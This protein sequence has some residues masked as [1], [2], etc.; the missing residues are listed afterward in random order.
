MGTCL[1][2]VLCR[3]ADG[4]R[5]RREQSTASAVQYLTLVSGGQDAAFTPQ[6]EA[7][8]HLCDFVHDMSGAKEITWEMNV[9]NGIRLERNV[10]IRVGAR[11]HDVKGG[12][13]DG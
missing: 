7:L 5:Y 12:G 13:G 8:T 11:V 10:F 9:Q 2:A 6:L 3:R 1:L 4:R